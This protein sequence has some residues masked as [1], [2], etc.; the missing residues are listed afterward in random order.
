MRPR[1]KSRDNIEQKI[2]EATEPMPRSCYKKLV[3]LGNGNGVIIA[4]YLIKYKL[5]A[6]KGVED[7][8]RVTV[9]NNLGVFARKVNKPFKK[10]TRQDV[11]LFLN[12]L[13]KSKAKDPRQKWRG[14]YKLY[15]FYIVQFFK[16]LYHPDDPPTRRKTP[17]VVL[18]LPKH[19]PQEKTYKPT[20]MWIQKEQEIFLKYCPDL[21][22]S[23]YHAI[24]SFTG[25]RPHEILGLKIGDLRWSPNGEGLTFEVTGKT[26]SRTLKIML[27]Y[28]IDF[29]QRWIERHPKGKVRSSYLIYSKKT[30]GLLAPRSLWTIYTRELKPYFTKL[31]DEAI[32]QED[33]IRIEQLL[34][35]PWTPYVIR[36]S[37][38]TECIKKKRLA[39][40][41][42]NK[43]YGWTSNSKMP[44]VYENL[45]EDDAAEALAESYG[46]VKVEQETIP[47]LRQCPN[48]T[49]KEM[50]NPDAP[51]CAKC[52]VPLTV[53]GFMER[54]N[55]MSQSNNV[56][57]DRMKERME[58]ME[59]QVHAFQDFMA[60]NMEVV[61]KLSD[62]DIQRIVE[63]RKQI[64]QMNREG[65]GVFNEA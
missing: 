45:G 29:I 12:G 57:V 61:S 36:H 49:C 14:T 59:Y 39:G 27:P 9:C 65:V 38:V 63:H 56:E 37:T 15:S 23:C 5:E 3:R 33:R 41:L 46:L 51:F 34:S 26:G 42:L 52:R 17:D 7:S 47:Q 50:N 1:A 40:K 53:A 11:L 62:K 20:D 13:K 24:A 60:R 32:G 10:V 6:S 28:Y 35:K 30:G 16:W 44:S 43:W 58:A 31:L 25:A 8:T 19:E 2:R 18:D 21:R 54:E 48:V 22:I 55:Q 4:N 64:E